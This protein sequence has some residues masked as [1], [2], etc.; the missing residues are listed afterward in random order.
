MAKAGFWA[1]D[2]TRKISFGKDGWW[3]A[4]DERIENRRINLLFS[5][6][7][8]KTAEGTYEITIGWDKVAVTI[9]DTPYVVTRVTD[10]GEQGLLLRLNDESEELLDPT[11]LH[12]GQDHV[13]YCWVKGGE[14]A[15][16]FL[17]P[18]YYQL[19]AHVQEDAATGSFMLRFG[20]IVH[21]IPI[22]GQE[23]VVSNQ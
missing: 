6:H 8:H 9:D 7:V 5:Q 22:G 12:V 19:A 18:A 13:L 10:D 11:T 4:N 3:Y 14:H 2:P 17:R 15:A 1:I 20:S 21:L 23:K 16:R